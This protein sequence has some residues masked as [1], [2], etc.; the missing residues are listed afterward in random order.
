MSRQNL[1]WLIETGVW[2]AIILIL[3]AFFSIAEDKVYDK[4]YNLKY[5]IERGP[6]ETKIYDKDYNLKYRIESDGKVYDKDWNLRYRTE[7]GGYK[8]SEEKGK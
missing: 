5:R 8:T 7:K 2:A 1:K 3:F 6:R 4:D